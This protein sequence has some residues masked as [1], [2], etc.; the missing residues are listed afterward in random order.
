M[1]NYVYSDNPVK[2]HNIFSYKLDCLDISSIYLL[3]YRYWDRLEWKLAKICVN[4]NLRNF[5]FKCAVSLSLNVHV[6]KIHIIL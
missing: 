5:D 3:S 4:V 2:A 6:E 1:K